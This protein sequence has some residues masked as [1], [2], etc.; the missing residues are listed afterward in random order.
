MGKSADTTIHYVGEHSTLEFA[1]AELSKYLG[2]MTAGTWS[3]VETEKFD[4]AA[5]QSTG[6]L[7]ICLENDLPSASL[8]EVDDPELDDGIYIDT[9]GS[10]GVI[11]GSNHR[12]VLLA[13]YRFLTEQ[14]CRWVRPGADGE[15]IPVGEEAVDGSV[16]RPVSVCESA[17][18]R[19]RGICIEGAVSRE[20]VKDIID[21]APKVGFNSYFTQFREAYTFFDRWYSH[22]GNPHQEPEGFS[23]EKARELL[24]G[25][26]GEIK[27]RD[28]LYHAVGHG[29]T[30][31]PF[32][33]S[34]LGWDYLEDD[35]APEIIQYLA[36]IDGRREYF[37][38]RP[39]NTNLCYSNAEV[40]RR[41]TEAIADYAGENP[42][43]DYLHF[44]LADGS[45]NNCECADCRGAR[46]SDFYVMMLNDLDRL[47]TDRHLD[48]RIVFLIYV[49]L[50]W[51]P[52]KER[53]ENP[54]RFVLMFAPITR[55]Y[56][57]TFA[58][59]G[60]I[61]SIPPYERNHLEFPANVSENVAFLKGWQRLFQGDSFDFDYH[62]MWDHYNDPGYTENV[63]VLNGDIALL[64]D[65][66]LGGFMSC[67]TQRAFFPTGFGMTVMG[68]SLWNR[69]LPLKE[70]ERDYFESAFGSDS[71]LCRKY[72][73]KL[74]RLFDPV[75]LRGEKPEKNEEAA[76][77]LSQIPGVVKEFRPVIERNASLPDPCR[78][79][80]WGYLLH[81]ADLSAALAPALEARAR[82]EKKRA[83]DLWE[84]LKKDLWTREEALHPVLDIWLFVRTAERRWKWF[85]EK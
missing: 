83:A 76:S 65:I 50:L 8:P 85:S 10:R 49:D 11:S 26:V 34:G 36:E 4:P 63:R 61:H 18:Y 15:H 73:E 77:A 47:L 60:A 80:S 28:M 62:Y 20:H 42:M 40:R 37:R 46:P 55:S 64:Q 82:G 27:K 17:S 38:G 7:W 78:S 44:W 69:D 59:E 71:E 9:T 32:G 5:V 30:C 48:T 74:T 52:E 13:V 58:P 16:L 2:R 43:V 33:V 19:H 54:D 53:I 39:I 79:A 23:V 84:K 21:W 72:L 12:S 51:P 14:G 31:E 45:N 22:T 70:M 67:Q 81:H 57:R 24:E 35:P 75:Y 56:S 6:G 1:A 41:V 25:L 68:W 29:W 3:A 66:R